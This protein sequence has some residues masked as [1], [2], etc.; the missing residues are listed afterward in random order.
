MDDRKDFFRTVKGG[1]ESFYRGVPM[2]SPHF[3]HILLTHSWG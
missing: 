1:K 3:I 2:R